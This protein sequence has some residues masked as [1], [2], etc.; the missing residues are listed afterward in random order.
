M[1]LTLTLTPRTPLKEL[2]RGNLVD[3]PRAVREQLGLSGLN[4]TTD[5]LKGA[6]RVAIA[7]LRDAADRAGCACLVLVEPPLP[8]ASARSDQAE[9]ALARTTRLVEAASLLGCN[10]LAL[11]IE[12][13]ATDEA[14]ERA[15]DALR[16]VAAAAEKRELNVLIAPTRG[17]TEEPER[18]TELIKRVGGFRI[19]TY[20]D[21]ATAAR[22]K[23]PV[24]YLRRLAPYAWAVCASTL[25]FAEPE[26]QGGG[27]A[28]G[29]EDEED[30]MAPAVHLSYD[31]DSM[32]E[33]VASVGYD[34][35]LAIDYRGESGTLGLE[36]SCEALDAALAR[37][38]GG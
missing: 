31:L 2:K 9:R 30:L 6:D 18:V 1:L 7:E 25:E 24:A 14:F 8:L 16:E 27:A 32:V 22:A 12:G 21:F 23:D 28:E 13:D 33:A 15:V 19:G 38:A 10:S 29:G 26:R 11:G 35:T 34:G 36:Q 17:I 20:P 3:V 37:L 5:L 4:V